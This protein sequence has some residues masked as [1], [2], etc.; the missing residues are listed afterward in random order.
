MSASWLES[1]VRVAKYE[2]LCVRN[3]QSVES[4]KCDF[5]GIQNTI[6][7]LL[8]SMVHCMRFHV[9]IKWSI[10]GWYPLVTRKVVQIMCQ[11][12]SFRGIVSQHTASADEQVCCQQPCWRGIE[13]PSTTP[14]LQKTSSKATVQDPTYVF[15]HIKLVNDRTVS[16]RK[17]H[18][19]LVKHVSCE[20]IVTTPTTVQI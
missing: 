19:H 16:A 12:T 13:R 14:I 20:A 6:R 9:R 1:E 11:R 17:K 3:E 10:R 4:T 15:V 18:L 8:A 2:P 7:F 5:S